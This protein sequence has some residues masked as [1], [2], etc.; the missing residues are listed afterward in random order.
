MLEFDLPILDADA[1]I[2]EAFAPMIDQQ[3]SAVVCRVGRGARIV[4]F[5]ALEA[6]LAGGGG[7]T[8]GDVE[9]FDLARVMIDANART[10]TTLLEAENVK[11][12]VLHS[13]AYLAQVVSVSELYGGPYLSAPPGS[14]CGNPS[15][16][17]YYPPHRLERARPNT[18]VVCGSPMVARR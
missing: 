6:A 10:A 7:L 17:H 1:P 8:L 16:A 15:R 12:A 13:G 3:K 5:A 18:C 9:Q 2:A 4:S 14:K 11:F